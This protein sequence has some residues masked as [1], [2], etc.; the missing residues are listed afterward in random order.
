MIDTI[1]E[2]SNNNALAKEFTVYQLLK[3]AFPTILMMIFMGL[4]TIVDTIFVAR[5]INTDALSAM[6]IIC[7]LNNFIVGLGTMLATGGSAIVAC[8]MGAG[9]DRRSR[10]DFTLIILVGFV[11]GCMI[12]VV[13]LIFL[14]SIIFALGAS[15]SLYP[16]CR[17]YLYILLL[18]TPASMLQVLF[19][20][21]IVTAGKPSLGM[22]LSISAGV[23]NI[24]LDYLFIV[25]LH[26]GM[27]GAALGTG[28]GYLIPSIIGFAFFIINRG[29][30]Y[31]NKPIVDFKVIAK[32]CLNGSS[33][34]VSQLA[35]A[36]TTFLF[37]ITMM[38]LAGEDGVAAITIMI[39]TQ[40]FASTLYIGFSM[41]V[42]P[43][44]SYNFGSNNSQNLKKIITI[45]LRFIICTSILICALLFIFAPNLAEVFSPSHTSVYKITKEG[46]LVFPLSF[47]FS[48]IN[49]FI[50]SM[51]T[52]LSNGKISAIISFLRTFGFITIGIIILAKLF[53]IIGVWLAVPIAEFS[54]IFISVFFII[55]YKKIYHYI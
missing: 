35:A 20:N 33:E 34:M 25:L 39:Y 55:K 28:I 41:G 42:A 14:R 48:G 50:S 47:L 45:C 44:V 29:T 24:I 38:K 46:F 53:G 32:S 17:D 16:Y 2:C 51:F 21:L 6:N 26:W 23:A 31:F 8:K 40:F 3:F 7:P 11:I 49:I 13:G 52:A 19:Q 43:V 12:A 9:E 18:F 37:N 27:K 30:L 54:T 1:N 5:F 36:I 10:Q 22:F 15:S 4:Y